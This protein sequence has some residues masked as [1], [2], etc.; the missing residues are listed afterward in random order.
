[1]SPAPPGR[2]TDVP[3]L[4][5]AVVAPSLDILGGQAVQANRLLRAWRD[6]PDVEA[7]LVPV[8]PVPPGVLRHLRSVK[9]ARTVATLLTYFPLLVRELSR[10][11]VAHVFAASYTSFLLAPLPAMILARAFRKPILLNYRS[12]HAPNHLKKSAITRRA[13][14]AADLNIVPSRFL[15]EVF[16]RF[17]I[18]AQTIPNIVDLDRFSYRERVPLRPHLLSTRN[19]E[20]LYNVACTIRAFRIVQNR[21]PDAR[22]TLVGGGP[23]TA[24]LGRLVAELGLR[25]VTFL[26]RIDPNNIS[27]VYA[28]SDIYIQSPNIDNMPTS[29]VEAFACGLPVVSTMAGGIPAILTSGVHG[30]LAPLDDHESLAAHV[31]TLLERPDYARQL[32]RA[33]FATCERCTWPAVRDQ[34]LRAYRS[35]T[36]VHR[37]VCEPSH[38]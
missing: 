3:R 30:L 14:A 31:L 7:W 27:E 20:G 29:V 32:A 38:V 26:G 16:A 13:L 15:V 21:W 34:W 4:R 1:M 25:N 11:D 18:A 12:G 9:Y 10:A 22:L 23:E 6:D 17:G 19:H 36:P 8:N 37:I 5:V 28:A 35:V 24:A 2:S 33:A